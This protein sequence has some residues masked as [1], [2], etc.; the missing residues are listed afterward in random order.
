MESG[1]GFRSEG[2]E[3]SEFGFCFILGYYKRDCLWWFFK[4]FFY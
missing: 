4:G 3:V 2:D 1:N